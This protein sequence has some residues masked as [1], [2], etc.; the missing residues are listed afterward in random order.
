MDPHDPAEQGRAS[1]LVGQAR[2]RYG[3][4]LSRVALLLLGSPPDAAE[5]VEATFAGLAADRVRVMV[6]QRLE[7]RL[8]R[9]LHQQ[10]RQYAIR[11]GLTGPL[12]AQGHPLFELADP[13]TGS[14]EAHRIEQTFRSLPL[15]LREL[16]ALKVYAGLSLLAIEDI[17]SE[18]RETIE[19]HLAE[20]YRIFGAALNITRGNPRGIENRL[21]CLRPVGRGT[22]G[23]S[24]VGPVPVAAPPHR[25]PVVERVPVAPVEYPTGVLV[26]V[27]RSFHQRLRRG[28]WYAAAVA[29]GALLLGFIA[30]EYVGQRITAESLPATSV[31]PGPIEPDRLLSLVRPID[32]EAGSP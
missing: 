6:S 25:E 11:H 30:A 19:R 4:A 3:E 14:D 32:R 2:E 5:V 17:L 28:L 26:A 24:P 10:A 12:P 7:G 20:V 1:R 31:P 16:V 8:W 23:R 21:K 22:P 15:T 13:T 27:E 9:A 18:S 29:V